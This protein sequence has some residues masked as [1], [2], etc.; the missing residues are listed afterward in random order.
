MRLGGE[1]GIQVRQ[2]LA[3]ATVLLTVVTALAVAGPSLAGAQR[4][5]QASQPPS[6]H[7]RVPVGG[8]PPE[9]VP[10]SPSTRQR[11]SRLS[12]G[13]PALWADGEVCS[14]GCRADAQPG[15]PLKPF[16]RQHGLRAALNELR[17]GTLHSGIDVQGRDGQEVYAIQGGRATIPQATGADARVRV[18][19][20]EYQHIVPAVTEG[21]R[22]TAYETVVGTIRRRHGHVHLTELARGRILNPLRPGG[23]MVDPY[24]DRE[25]PVI[26]TPI[27]DGRQVYVR[28]FDPQTFVEHT[29]Y[30]T[31]VLAPAALA[32]RVFSALGAPIGGLH[33]A[34]RGSRRHPFHLKDKIYA[35]GAKP[36]GFLCLAAERSCRP[37]WHYR[38]A[39]GMA[40]PLP[41]LAPGVYRLTV[42]AWDWTGNVTA[43]DAS[44]RVR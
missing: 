44:F 2:C 29:T 33:W 27:F 30:T 26:G 13:L 17:H 36:A 20:F 14:V 31:P 16:H 9:V 23:R 10:F 39:G 38:L 34:L 19:N 40:R 12:D 6:P 37:N 5:G 21:E 32:Y 25:P 15:W 4:D 28:A 18:G 42:Y 43:R 41:N 35:P 22:V 1:I 24:T 3:R 7:S 11:A 8:H